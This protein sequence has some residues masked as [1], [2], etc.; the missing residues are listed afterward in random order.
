MNVNVNR[1]LDKIQVE[2]VNQEV[3]IDELETNVFVL[4]NLVHPVTVFFDMR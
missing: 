3:H 4:V 1:K 2:V